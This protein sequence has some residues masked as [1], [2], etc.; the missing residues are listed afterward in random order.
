MKKEI[1][2]SR[3]S[4]MVVIAGDYP[5]PKHKMFVFVQQ[6]V[7]S[8]IDLGVSL[9]VIAPQSIT[10]AIIHREKLLPRLTKEYTPNGNGYMVF[11]PYILTSGNHNIISRFF[12]KINQVLVQRHLKKIS[13]KT[14]YAHFWSSAQMVSN[15]ALSR[16]IPLFVACGE[17]DNAIEDMMSNSSMSELNILREA[18]TGIVSVSS[19]N[20][21]KCIDYKLA[22][23]D[24]IEVFPNCVD[25]SLFKPKAV[26]EKKKLLGINE[27]D[28]VIVFVGGFIPRK[29]PDRLASAIKRINDPSIKAIFIG[30]PFKGYPYDFDCPGILFKGPANHEDIA[31]Y[32]NCADV[33]VLPTKKEGCCN[34]IV[35]A[36]AVGLPIISSKGSFNDDILDELNS[37]R[38]SPDSVEEIASA[39]I[40]LKNN[41]LLMR[42][43]KSV[44]ISR[45]SMYSVE[46]RA[47][48][49][50]FFISNKLIIL[51]NEESNASVRDTSRGD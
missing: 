39:I 19:E 13:F 12:L 24:D 8:F 32:L 18:V 43:M 28:F 15:Y 1:N 31:D 36:L 42:K 33:F 29:G 3:L 26:F 49:I 25:I 48:K 46:D 50:L 21:R 6:L 41:P 40:E 27:G 37:I 17:G 47:K 30:K 11:R 45:H 4:P 44:S 2:I 5:A 23:K 38:I 51:N 9:A 35:E 22:N 14:I 20:K 34:S 10:H 16:R 7:H